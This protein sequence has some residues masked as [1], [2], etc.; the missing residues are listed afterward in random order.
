MLEWV[1]KRN[2]SDEQIGYAVRRVAELG[3]VEQFV[4]FIATLRTEIRQRDKH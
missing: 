4:A 1:K 2:F 3:S